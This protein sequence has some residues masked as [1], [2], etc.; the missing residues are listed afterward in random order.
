MNPQIATIL[1]DTLG[2][3]PE[4][5]TG[6][7]AAATTPEW[8]S[9]AHLNVC[10]SV[11]QTFGLTLTPEEMMAMDSVESIEAVLARHAAARE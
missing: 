11:E 8:D 3:A 4:A 2:L 10:L 6:S 5:V 1:Q 9:I 7:L